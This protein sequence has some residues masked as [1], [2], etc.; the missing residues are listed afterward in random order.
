MDI[1]RNTKRNE[2]Q[3]DACVTSPGKGA[4]EEEFNYLGGRILRCL[5]DTKNPL[6]FYHRFKTLLVIEQYDVVHSHSYYF[7]GLILRA[8]AQAGVPKRVAHIHPVEDQKKGEFLRGLYAWWMK[9]WIRRYGTD[10]VG[11]TRASL[12]AFWGADWQED[13]TKQ[14]VYNGIKVDRFT[15]P[16]DREGVRKE[17]G[18]PG[19]APIVINVSRFV[20]HKRHEFLVQVAERV[21]T[22]REDVC[23]LLIGAGPLKEKIEKQVHS[24]ALWKNFRFI[25]DAPNV[26]NYWMAADLFAFPSCNE[27]F[28]IVIIEATAAGLKVI[29]QDI[30]GVREAVEACLDPVLL[31]VETSAEEWA[32]VLLD[33]MKKP[34]MSESQRQRLLKEFP[35]TIENSVAKLK[36]IYRR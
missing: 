27:G 28:G 20:P 3:I 12:G 32:H 15:K 9:R 13:P 19:G 22:Q 24:K 2:L 25:S 4:Y 33:A 29:A 10:F 23:F 7:S 17:L 36:E 34:R 16:V 5:L 31:P 18:I 1:M 35:F 8:A 26:D 14:V 11:P 21:K 30:P 6:S